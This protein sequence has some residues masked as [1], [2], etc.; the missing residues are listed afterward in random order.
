MAEKLYR[1]E[2]MKIMKKT[3]CLVL[4]LIMALS[5]L[6]LF[7]SAE[8][9]AS[10]D[11]SYGYSTRYFTEKPDSYGVG[12]LL[13]EADTALATANIYEVIEITK[14]IKFVI[15]L[16]NVNALCGTLDSFADLL[17]NLLIQA[18][19]AVALGDLKDLD[20]STW[21][22]GMKRSTANDTVI[23]KEVVEFVN[24]NS[25]IISG[26]VDGSL[27]LGVLKNTVDLKAL[28]GED[29]ISGIIK[30]ALFGV[31]YSGSEL[32]SA[33]AQYKE[34]VDSFIYGPLLT[35]LAGEYLTGFTM[36][37]DT[38]VEDLLIAVADSALRQYA[39]PALK[40]INEDFSTSPV[41]DLRKLAPYMNLKGN[42]YNLNDF[43]L[44][45]EK[46][47]LEQLNNLMGVLA[48][49]I[50][51]GSSWESGDYTLIND[52]L[53]GILKH[54]GKESGLIPDA[55][56]MSFTE[57]V[58]EVVAIVLRNL[59]LGSY[60]DGIA[61]CDTLED[62][63]KSVIATAAREEGVTTTYT[64]EDSWLV[65]LCDLFSA[66]AYDL[67][68]IKDLDGKSYR[69]GNGD[70]IW[71]ALNYF[72]NYF[73]FDKKMGS[74]MGI[75]VTKQ[76][77]FFTKIDKILDLFGE[78][79]KAGVNFSLEKFLLGDGDT[80]GVIDSALT[81]DLE[82]VFTITF[83]AAL[84]AAG[85]VK[86]EKFLYNT[87]RYFLNNWSGEGL[88]PAYV[89]G[90]AFTAALDNSN[91]AS[92]VSGVLKT[93]DA[94]KTPLTT[95]VAF[96]CAL[97]L[98]EAE[99]GGA[100]TA[101]AENGYY[102]GYTVHP[103]GSVTLGGEKLVQGED[104]VV[105]GTGTAM[106]TAYAE[107][108]LIGIYEG[109]VIV[110]Y[111]IVLAPVSEVRV[112]TTDTKVR[113]RWDQVPGADRYNVYMGDTLVETVPADAEL[114][115]QF[116]GLT[117]MT[118]YNFS[119]EAVSDIHGAAE[120][121]A[122]TALTNPPKVGSVKV[123]SVTAS[124]ATLSWNAVPGAKGY[125]VERY[126]ASKKAYVS[127]GKTSGTSYTVKGL[128]SYTS[129][130]F[131]VKAYFTE[132]EDTVYSASATKVSARTK[133]GKVENLKASSKTS[134]SITLSW[135]KVRNAKGYRIEQYINGK[136]TKL[137]SITGTSYTVKGL[138]ASSK[139]YFR[140]RAY[141]NS[142]NYGSYSDKLT[143]YT[144]LPKV[145]GLKVSSTTTSSAKLSWKK[146]TGA[147]SYVIYRSTNG[148]TWTKVKTTTGTSY[149]V[150][151]LYSGTTYQFKVVAYSNKLKTYGDYSSVVKGV[152]TVGKVEDLKA[153]SRKKTSITVT[154][155]KER[156]AAGYV[157]YVSPDGK[158]WTKLVTTTKNT[159]TASNLTKNKY[160]YFKVRAY[161]KASGS[162]VYGSYS[163]TL[164]AKTTLF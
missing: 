21:K 60:E 73:L 119:V 157:V 18:A 19:I 74:F 37:S 72:L 29:G 103:D 52:N 159:A 14:D 138:R 148:K 116:T 31:V 162:T 2:I 23:L 156:G 69:G 101:S 68:D 121:V 83:K 151:G 126:S 105:I 12:Q 112:T 85:D 161:S 55:D 4:C 71:T 80:K 76:D 88:L 49:E 100:F 33:Y 99:P 16:R 102:T 107:V 94:R 135:D 95:I 155:D 149:T 164:K 6:P 141:Y 111:N 125:V 9:N 48:R 143:V 27:N 65:V 113:L 67:F 142:A 58:M 98:D 28:L 114:T 150:T 115:K 54:L 90:K 35:K 46:G 41:E 146:V 104:Y 47:L 45:P 158:S 34:D 15:D 11:G 1:R 128:Y 109:S 59:D 133:M 63:L 93:L 81:L 139:Y 144:N 122:A 110:P 3:L 97:A 154:W 118:R 108:R 66:W 62:L 124:T 136:W 53:E 40:K 117:P 89:Q 70:D 145:T 131:R 91:I 25:S 127:A 39:I 50:F 24:A 140:V 32:D 152:T 26:I 42:T 57:I 43:V 20:F 61:E 132:G 17:D 160:Y 106:G 78:T 120:K 84:D 82:N 64:E 87:I 38:T 75:S 13:D 8:G 36:T 5:S 7:A 79:K 137:T 30:E 129:Y 153:S 51:P 56:E 130:D 10:A 147:T 134:S 77:S 96:T 163:T 44:D 92:L 123:T 22:T 86:A